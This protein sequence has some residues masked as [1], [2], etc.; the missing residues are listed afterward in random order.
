MGRVWSKTKS[1]YQSTQRGSGH[2]G[3][4]GDGLLYQWLDTCVPGSTPGK[5]ARIL[6][7]FFHEDYDLLVR[8]LETGS[9]FELI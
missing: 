1:R 8:C 7:R 6:V 4:T 5:P 2:P 9:F 3:K